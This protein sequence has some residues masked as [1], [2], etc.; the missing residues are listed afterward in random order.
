MNEIIKPKKPNIKLIEYRNF[1]TWLHR[2]QIWVSSD[3]E[4]T[5]VR[6]MSIAHIRNIMAKIKRDKWRLAFLP[7]FEAELK[8]R[9]KEKQFELTNLIEN[10]GDLI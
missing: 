2:N 1:I 5:D 6:D 3:Y 9:I 4:L 10:I 7:I 8:R